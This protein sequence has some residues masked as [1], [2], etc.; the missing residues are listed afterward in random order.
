MVDLVAQENKKHKT[1]GE[2]LYDSEKYAEW[3]LDT[4]E[5]ENKYDLENIDRKVYSRIEDSLTS[6]IYNL[7]SE[8]ER[9]DD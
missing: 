9:V 1:N 8:L 5:E 6:Y 7:L 3:L 4:I 2:Q